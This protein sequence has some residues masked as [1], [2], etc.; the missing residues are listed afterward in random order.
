SP[1]AN[2]LV[3]DTRED[4]EGALENPPWPAKCP[5]NLR[6]YAPWVRLQ[7]VQSAIRRQAIRP[8]PTPIVVKPG[9][10]RPFW[11]GERLH[12]R[13]RS[14]PVQPTSAGGKLLAEGQKLGWPAEIPSRIGKVETGTARSR[15][16]V[17][18]DKY[19]VPIHFETRSGK[20]LTW[21]PAAEGS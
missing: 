15:L 10:D 17:L 21:K 11:D 9:T 20:F 4:F 19:H 3:A 1:A 8:A 6:P 12:Y 5:H 2:V 13:G 7:P 18:A 16:N 14:M